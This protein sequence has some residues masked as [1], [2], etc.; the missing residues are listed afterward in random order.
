[1]TVFGCAALGGLYRPITEEDAHETLETAWQLGARAFDTA[2]HYG[3]GQSEEYLGAFLR[4]KPR[5]SFTISTKVGRLLVDDPDAI[6]GTDGFFGAPLRSRVRDYSADGVR[7]SLEQSLARLGLDRVDTV[8]VHDPEVNLRQALDE[9]APALSALRGEGVIDSYGVGTNFSAVAEAFVRET[10]ADRIMI[11]GR[12]SVLDR[13]AEHDLLALSRDRG[14]RVLV[15]GVL[16]SGLL[17]D[18]DRPGAMFNYEPAPEWL[19]QA[20]REMAG[21]CA[22]YGVTL[23]AAALQFPLRHPDIEDVVTGAGRVASV[24]DTHDQL[25]VPIPA[26]LWDELDDLVPDQAQL[27]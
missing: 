14:T 1:M 19:V 3:V 23:R 18:P 24:R 11:A 26:A 5:R 15:A 4:T 16:N 8:L 7:R 13:R 2:P 21:A 22:R 12:Y 25:A 20:A 6:D 9:A 17:A 27:P 10:D